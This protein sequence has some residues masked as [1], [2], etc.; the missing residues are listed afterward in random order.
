MA[1]P[2]LCSKRWRAAHQERFYA[3]DQ[4]EDQRLGSGF[5]ADD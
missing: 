1:I 2:L 3:G 4:V 5:Y